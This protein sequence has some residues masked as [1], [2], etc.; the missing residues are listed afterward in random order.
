VRP[1][2]KRCVLA[3]ILAALLGGCAASNLSGAVQPITGVNGTDA[4]ILLSKAEV[5][6]ALGEQ[7][8]E[9]IGEQEMGS[10]GC[11]YTPA[12]ASNNTVSIELSPGSA[13]IQRKRYFVAQGGKPVSSIGDEALAKG[14]AMLV[15]QHNTIV[16]LV[17]LHDGW[18]EQ[19]CFT[20]ASTLMRQALARIP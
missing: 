11:T 19:R 10:Y 12:A 13:F 17:L 6:T 14:G 18:D 15:L 8:D 3:V 1:R 7:L 5:A 9:P 2:V 4:C 16:Y 20:A